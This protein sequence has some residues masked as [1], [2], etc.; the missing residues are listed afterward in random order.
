MS[1]RGR[2]CWYVRSDDGAA[3]KGGRGAGR[4]ESGCPWKTATARAS[5]RSSTMS[6]STEKSSTRSK[7]CRA[8]GTVARPQQHRPTTLFAGLS[9][10]SP[11]AWLQANNHPG[12]GVVGTALQQLR[13]TNNPLV[14][15][16]G[17]SKIVTDSLSP[18]VS[19]SIM[20]LTGSRLRDG[21]KRYLSSPQYRS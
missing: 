6:C 5:T 16:I 2:A 11:E 7:R 19:C 1:T 9:T 8:R 3:S 17:Q 12:T 10:A 4:I 18:C 21:P 13:Y 20:W 15:K 14:Q